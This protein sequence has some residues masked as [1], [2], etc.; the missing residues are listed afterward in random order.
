[1]ANVN[2]LAH[3]YL[4]EDSAESLIGNLM[5]DFARGIDPDRLDPQV[6]AGLARHR[7]VDRLTDAHPVH[8]HS[9]SRLRAEWGHLAAVLVD[10]FY[11]HFLARNWERYS[12]ITLEAFSRRVYAALNAHPQRLSPR[13]RA[14]AP[15]IVAIDLLRGY[16]SLSG[17]ERI[18]EG[19]A[20]RLRRPI[21]LRTAVTSL[22]RLYA[23]LG[24]DFEAFFPALIA[25]ATVEDSSPAP[26][27]RA[28]ATPLTGRACGGT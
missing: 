24:R 4:A 9:R 28:L 22:R 21:P 23:E 1:M 27:R 20:R 10:V 6:R 11:D 14:A 18:L 8:R 15:R 13:L 5:G 17:V 2:Y 12:P 3:L 16:R 26:W 19:M 7:R 25:A